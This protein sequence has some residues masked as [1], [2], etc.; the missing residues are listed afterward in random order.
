MKTKHVWF[1]LS[2]LA[3]AGCS[4]NEITE[5]SPEAN[6]EVGFSVFTGTQTKGTITDNTESG[7]GIKAK[8]FGVL[9]YYTGATDDGWMN[10][11]DASVVLSFG[12]LNHTMS[13]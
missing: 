11:R 4:Q 9:A 2:A 6:P 3:I 5:I 8:G 7:T 10:A 13:A 12:G 1:A